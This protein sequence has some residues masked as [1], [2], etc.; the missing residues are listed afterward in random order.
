MYIIKN[1]ESENRLSPS[2]NL[3]SFR[4][5]LAHMALI[6]NLI[7]PPLI[8]LHNSKVMSKVRKGDV[9]ATNGKVMLKL[10]LGCT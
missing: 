6:T 5:E 2:P 1:E 7:R 10:E 8:D 3:V 4:M 9:K